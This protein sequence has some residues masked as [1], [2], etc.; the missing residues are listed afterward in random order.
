MILRP[1]PR[2]VFEP[3]RAGALRGAWNVWY[4]FLRRT[5]LRVPSAP[6]SIKPIGLTWQS[7]AVVL[8]PA[9]GWA[10]LGKSSYFR[11]AALMY[12]A[13]AVIAVLCLGWPAA[14]WAAGVMITLHGLGIAEYF[15][16][17]R[18]WPQPTHRVGRYVGVVLALAFVYTI[19]S[20]RVLATVVIPLHTDRGVLLIDAWTRPNPVERDAIVAFRTRGWQA[21]GFRL[22]AGVYLGRAIGQPGDVV[23]FHAD[24]FTVN[25]R[26]YPRRPSMPRHGG[27]TVPE[28]NTFVW[29]LELGREFRN[30]G[31]AADFARKAALV[32]DA[33][34]VG[35]PYRRWFLRQQHYEPFR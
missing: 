13:C 10:A 3:P 21:G 35:R 6:I 33:N 7:V 19:A 34:L 18:L 30:E 23:T 29:P 16:S 12:G 32:D 22:P 2:P 17:G 8:I 27:L 1:L 28:R 24:T 26:A 15:Y 31:E 20:R 11:W 25:G 14:G 5:H 9:Y 4:A